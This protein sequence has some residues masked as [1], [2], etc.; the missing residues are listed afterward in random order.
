MTD[1]NPK[2]RENKSG[3]YYIL[4]GI[5]LI[6]SSPIIGFYSVYLYSYPVTPIINMIN[7]MNSDGAMTTLILLCGIA[8]SLLG[9][10]LVII[11]YMKNIISRMK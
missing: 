4:T 8:C 7:M 6:L 2:K 9:L 1:N 10:S 3:R 5:V 11:G